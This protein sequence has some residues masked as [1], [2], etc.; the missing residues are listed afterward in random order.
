MSAHGNTMNSVDT[1]TQFLTAKHFC[2]KLK[3]IM[4]TAILKIGNP[5]GELSLGHRFWVVLISLH[6]LKTEFNLSY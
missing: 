5:T 3:S 6:W 1:G 4:A 2:K